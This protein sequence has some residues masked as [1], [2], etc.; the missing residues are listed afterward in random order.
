MDLDFG[1]ARG[2]GGKGAKNK[3]GR[4]SMLFG[5]EK[6]STHKVN[7][8][9]MDMNLSSPY[10]LPPGIHNSHESI[11]SLA[12]T[13]LNEQDPY[14]SVP[15]YVASEN[16]S[17]RSFNPNGGSSKRASVLTGRSVGTA[18]MPPP[19]V[20]SLPRTPLETVISPGVDE[21]IDPFATPTAPE[22][23]RRFDHD[24]EVH[25]S[26]HAIQ[27]VVPE[28]GNAAYPDDKHTSSG[29]EMPDV[30]EL[31]E[32]RQP[33]VALSRDHHMRRSSSPPIG[34]AMSSPPMHYDNMAGVAHGGEDSF[35]LPPLPQQEAT[36]LGL[37]ME[38]PQVMF[39]TVTPPEMHDGEME[40]HMH[41]HI[42]TSQ[43]YDDYE[44]QNQEHAYAADVAD[45]LGVPQP[46]MRRLSVGVVPLP[47]T[48]VME[49]DDP[50]YRANRIRSFYKEYFDD[51]KE[52]A[53]P[54]P[55]QQYG[56]EY[57]DDY[58]TN[59][60]GD[61]AYYD[62]DTNAFV[63]PYAQP[64]TRRAMTP[65]PGGRPRGPPGPRGGP[66][67]PRI[68]HG[69]HGSLGGMSLP[70]GPRGRAGSAFGPRP[71]SS[72][73]GRWG[74]QPPRKKGPP[75]SDLNTLPTPSKLRDD[76][77]I[78][79]ATDFAP[80]DGFREHAA[81]RSQSPLGERRAYSPRAPVASPLVTAF[82]ELSVLPSP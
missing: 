42:Q 22:P 11:H 72:A 19:R 64:V 53:P 68:P 75:P 82:D 17:I 23:S 43:Y 31:P 15:Q 76:S 46:D 73:S 20:N 40:S 77:A 7:Q 52:A 71:G 33:P 29:Y 28:I 1:Y 32:I 44:D 2:P 21:K 24:A 4:K 12:R 63:M 6:I 8:L 65:P 34:H 3:A 49:S 70:G 51:H 60:L 10:L 37:D 58:D 25:D 67:G 9:S 39:P 38:I 66:R 59:Y 47:P 79:N 57:Y 30:P 5:G 14:R 48:D 54:L 56:S 78:F 41:P 45:G 36:G 81:G 74:R 61:A 35:Q 55:N 80:P 69:P 16:G 18:K 13:F 50:E 62:P 26:P 27:P